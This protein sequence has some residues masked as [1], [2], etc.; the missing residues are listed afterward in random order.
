MGICFS[1]RVCRFLVSSAV[2]TTPALAGR[3]VALRRNF[4][5]KALIMEDPCV[6]RKPLSAQMA[7]L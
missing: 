2:D 3:R 5:I 4:V 6:V 1:D 7:A